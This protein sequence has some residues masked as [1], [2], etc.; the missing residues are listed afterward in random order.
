MVKT[1]FKYNS[2]AE[3]NAASNRPAT[4]PSI[5]LAGDA[6]LTDKANTITDTSNAELGDHIFWDKQAGKR[7][8]VKYGTLKPSTVDSER[9]AD[10]REI[11]VGTRY[12]KCVTMSIDRLA[13]KKFAETDEWL[14]SG[15]DL[16]Q[17]GSFTLT[18]FAGDGSNASYKKVIN[19]SWSAGATMASV[20]A[21]ITGITY[22]S[23]IVVDETSF[24]V[25]LGGW[26]ANTRVEITNGSGGGASLTAT[27]EYQ[28]YQYRYYGDVYTTQTEKATGE[29]GANNL[30]WNHDKTYDYYS[31][32][33]ADSATTVDDPLLKKS[34]F[35]ATDNP[36][37]Y[38][39]FGGDYD[40]YFEEN[41]RRRKVKSP[42]WR[43]GTVNGDARFLFGGDETAKLAAVTHTRLDGATVNDFPQHYAA[44]LVGTTIPGAVT[45]FEPGTGHIGG[46]AEYDCILSVA[47]RTQTDRISLS[48]LEAGGTRTLNS[49]S[50]WLAFQRTATY[51]WIF[52]GTYGTLNSYSRVTTTYAR[53]FHAFDVNEF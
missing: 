29:K 30:N 13:S 38:N 41:F 31:V 10:L 53:V 27:R 12:G 36:D 26:S 17:A 1:I 24:G 35:N 34:A 23:A 6:P 45:G 51:G 7:V 18:A 8:L 25:L 3:Y 43:P 48:L 50:Y 28:G 47:N 11:F 4:S 20:V 14:V 42:S 37:L 40:A 9:Y 19:V 49:S 33:G 2:L 39:A 22:S 46:F 32:N 44:T 5:S 15:L 52:N 21:Q 16:T